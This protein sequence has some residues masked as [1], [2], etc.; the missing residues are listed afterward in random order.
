MARKRFNEKNKLKIIKLMN[1]F[2]IS[3][4]IDKNYFKY[5]YRYLIF[6]SLEKDLKKLRE[7]IFKL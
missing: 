4:S 2:Y 6:S 1:I 3:K 5:I 7:E